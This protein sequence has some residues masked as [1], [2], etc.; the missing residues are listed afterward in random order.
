MVG[1]VIS[2]DQLESPTPGLIAQMTGKLTTK[3]YKHATVYVLDQRS[4][5]GYVRLQKTSSA[6]ETIVG[7][8]AFETYAR[9]H[10]ITVKNYLADN[11][12]FKANLWV[13]EC[14]KQGQGLTFAGVNAHHQNGVAERRIC[15][16]QDMARTMLI[17]ANSRWS[18]SVTTNLWPYAIRMANEAINNTPSFQDEDGKTPVELFANSK[19]TANLNTGSR[20]VAQYTYWTTHFN[21]ASRFTSGKNGAR[22]RYTWVRRHNMDAQ[23]PLC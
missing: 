5:F 12:I 16:L 1:E 13:E 18:E 15:E 21:P 11:G 20:S 7:K 4:R 14:K 23:W 6:E 22:W 3:R 19:V 2:V 10:G 17:H 8:R 9:R